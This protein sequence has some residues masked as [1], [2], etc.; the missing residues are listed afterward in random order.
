MA[1]VMTGWLWSLNSA[2]LWDST[3]STH[4][5]SRTITVPTKNEQSSQFSESLFKVVLWF[6]YHGFSCS[7]GISFAIAVSTNCF[8]VAYSTSKSFDGMANFVSWRL[9]TWDRTSRRLVDSLRSSFCSQN[10]VARSGFECNKITSELFAFARTTFE[11]CDTNSSV[12]RIEA[13]TSG[14]TCV[15]T[16]KIKIYC[17]L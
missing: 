7:T 8:R 14:A 5:G 16:F 13:K 1:G 9:S 6:E 11:V 10:F 4:F 17:I 3:I 12:E 15:P 2:A